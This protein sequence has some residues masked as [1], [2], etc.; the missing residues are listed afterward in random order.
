MM[1]PEQHLQLRDTYGSKRWRMTHLYSIRDKERRVHRLR[2]NRIQEILWRAVEGMKPIRHFS[3]K[4]RQGGVSTFWLI[5]WLDDTIWTPNTKTGILSHK[6]E[7]LGYLMDMVRLAYQTMPENVRPRLGVEKATAL[8]FEDIGST[9][10]ASLSIRS[11]GVHNLH[12]SEWCWC[13]DTEIAASLGATGPV[14][15]VTGE[16]TGHGVG[17]DGHETYQLA[18]Q[19]KS[20][21]RSLFIPW[22]LQEEYI[23]PSEG[24]SVIRTT[25]ERKLEA[26]AKKDYDI[27]ITDGQVLFR[28]AKQKEQKWLFPQ[29]FPEND[30]EA[31]LAS[32]FPFFN[33][34]K[35]YAL[36]GEA[37]DHAEKN[38]PKETDEYTQWEAPQPG[39]VYVAGADIAEGLQVGPRGERDFSV[40]A[41]LCV[42]CRRQAF[43]WRGRVGVDAFYRVCDQWG[44]AY[45][46]ARLAPECNNHGHAVILGLR[47][48]THYPNLYEEDQDRRLVIRPNQKVRERRFGWDTT[49]L[50]KPLMLDHLKIALEGDSTE[51]E[52]NFQPEFRVYDKILLTEALTFQSEDGKLSAA[53]SKHDDCVMAWAI[54]CQLYLPERRNMSATKMTDILVGGKLESA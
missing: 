28:R 41:I 24:V 43:R 37:K 22:Y 51:D 32:G 46:C 21:Y 44:R 33:N 48:I 5:Y 3:L 23:L 1:T 26:E 13:E 50:T 6:L 36:Y 7:S 17:N 45:N 38:P 30:E 19:G 27:E 29:E 4:Y 10:F 49:T 8:S 39:H 11:T 54:A 18:K 12:I 35:L 15:N 31:F 42:T 25:D 52:Y 9:I 20:P 34:R 14:S 16:T 47:E 2:F 53:S 40:L